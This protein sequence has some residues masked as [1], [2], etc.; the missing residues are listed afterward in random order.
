MTDVYR[1]DDGAFLT[2]H[3]RHNHSV[4]LV[5]MRR[6]GINTF[7]RH[8]FNSHQ[9][10]KT[11]NQMYIFVDL[12]NLVEREAFPFWQLT[13][14]RISD[15][16]R[17]LV[18][19]RELRTK[20]TSIF[21]S[22]IQYQNLQ[23]TYDGV[24]EALRVLAENNIEPV[25]FFNRFDRVINMISEAFIDNVHGM[26]DA[27]D[28]KLSCVFTSYRPLADFYGRK[29]PFDLFYT[30]YLKPA[31]RENVNTQ[32]DQYQTKYKVHFDTKTRDAL[33]ELSGGHFH[34]LRLLM[35]ILREAKTDPE[36]LEST[37]LHEERIL[38]LCEELWESLNDEEKHKLSRV[39]V[40]ES[41]QEM[42]AYLLNTG[43]VQNGVIF[44]P[45]FKD[46]IK[47]KNKASKHAVQ[48][49]EFTRKEHAL[50]LVLQEHVGAICDRDAIIDKVW[51]E[52]AEDGISDWS[53]DKLM[54]RL[55]EKIKKQGLP[56]QVVTVRTRGYKLVHV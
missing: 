1:H 39:A 26:Y 32:I 34:Y 11:D 43:M 24:R 18:S 55:R 8:F 46:F 17:D 50:F 27:S 51:P 31:D 13:L 53:I 25:I 29:M 22:S 42:P 6:V 2:E 23:L 40:S 47:E 38:L 9:Y 10:G 30:R 41:K 19:D 16:V 37:A 14:K 15:A 49:L 5:G 4:E 52:S 44:S 12:N 28:H 3:L 21:E 33:V 45:L 35:D 56:Y 48:S 54:E 20:V 36:A 7:L